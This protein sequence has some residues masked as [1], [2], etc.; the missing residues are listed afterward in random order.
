MDVSLGS[1]WGMVPP[2]KDLPVSEF[3]GYQ[4]SSKYQIFSYNSSG[5]MTQNW[6]E[7]KRGTFAIDASLAEY[8][9]IEGNGVLLVEV[10]LNQL[11][12]VWFPGTVL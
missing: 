7:R 2:N 3:P 5:Q 1:Y 9:G 10:A 8:Y 4:K 11:H 12:D 6:K